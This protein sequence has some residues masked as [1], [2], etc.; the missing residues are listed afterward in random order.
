MNQ[1][2]L[3]ST[4]YGHFDVAVCGG[5]MSG[6]AAAIAA[7]RQ[8]ARS[9]LV[10]RA[11]WLGGM[12][13]TGAT[14]LHSFFNIFDTY[15][16]APRMRIAAGIAQELVD[17]TQALGGAMGHI[18]M[19]RGGDF[20]SM[21]TPV[22]PETFKLAAFQLC[23][24]AGVTLLLHT[25]IDEVSATN[26]HIDHLVVWNKGGRSRLEATQYIDCT[27]DGDLAAWAG[28]TWKGFDP[29]DPGAYSAGF[30]FR[31]V[32]I[33][34]Q[35]LESGLE[36]R[37]M[38]TQLAHAVK[39]GTDRLDLVRLG[40]DFTSLRRQGISGLPGYFLSS[41]LRPRE[42]TYCNC[43]NYG[44]NNGLD[45]LALTEAEISLRSQMM[46]V[47]EL[48]RTYLP[49]CEQ[50]YPAGPAPTAGQRRARAIRCQYELSQAD[51]VSGAH[52]DDQIGCFGF[53]DNHKYNVEQAGA[54]GI[55]YRALLP[56]D[57]D[58]LLISGR[59]MTVDTVAHN[60][61]RNTVC[62]LIT[63]QAAGTAAA[64]SAAAGRSPA[65]LDVEHLRATLVKSNA[66]LE[67]RLDPLL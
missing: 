28:A 44:P 15:P 58:N 24:E 25:I 10:E 39:P 50:A 62:C 20:V 7:A 19:Q 65:A 12:G 40:I 4:R 38:I 31:M 64:L 46:V 63:G 53:I 47:A 48:F 2:V 34:L 23:R 33:D 51:C 30:T 22:E 14:G 61:T 35:R 60:S 66:L 27:G 29:G 55:P 18:R 21:L 41:S 37:G 52:F 11:G 36:E 45:E 6:I 8:G 13:I 16:G 56:L 67:P 5:G 1:P 57:V 42:I 26:G 32:N 43:I 3:S 49:G 17:R 59:M 54:Y 9:V